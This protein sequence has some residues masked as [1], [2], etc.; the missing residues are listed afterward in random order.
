MFLALNCMAKY[1]K[2]AIIIIS[3]SE[4][5]LKCLRA[6]E[7][8]ETDT[9]KLAALFLVPKLVRGSECDK[10][11]RIHIMQVRLCSFK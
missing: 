4:P 6:L 10:S 9:E 1:V 5:V 7:A 2:D 3:L 8:A 11:A